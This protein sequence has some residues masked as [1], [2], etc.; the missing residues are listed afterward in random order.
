L[1]L[2]VVAVQDSATA[3]TQEEVEAEVVPH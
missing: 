3:Q 2:A 1:G